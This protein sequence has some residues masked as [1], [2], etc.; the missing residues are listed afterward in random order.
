MFVGHYA[1]SLA[2]KRLAPRLS[3]GWTFL[4]VQFLDLIWAPAILLGIEHARIRPGYLAASPLVLFDMP[5]THSFLMAIAWSWLLFRISKSPAIGICVFSHWVLDFI[6][7]APD[8]PLYRGGPVVGLGLWRSQAGTVGA[9]TVLLILGLL[10]YLRATRAIRPAG[11]WAMIAFTTA[12]VV[13]GAINVYGPP[14][15]NIR[16]IAI[17]A[18]MAYV[19]F[20][21]VAAWLDR[22]RAPLEP[23]P[24]TRLNLAEA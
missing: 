17:G 24:P 21:A 12:L 4:A 9:E 10:V 15:P 7:H 5:W 18:E 13:V 20:A 14:P 8:L 19:S 2:V 23:E 1:V 11:Q 3:L 16:F 6:A 22:F